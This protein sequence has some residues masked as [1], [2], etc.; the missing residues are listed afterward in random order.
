VGYDEEWSSRRRDGNLGLS[1]SPARLY[2]AISRPTGSRYK[3]KEGTALKHTF[4]PSVRPSMRSLRSAL[5]PREDK[6]DL[7]SNYRELYADPNGV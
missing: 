4:R 6:S 7:S 3:S 2:I 1:V 5:R